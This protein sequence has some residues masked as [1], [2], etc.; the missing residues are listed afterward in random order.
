[1]NTQQHAGR[2]ERFVRR[3]EYDD[4]HVVAVDLPVAGESV[5][6]EA[7]DETAIVVIDLGDEVV[8]TDVELPGAAERVDATNGVVTVEVAK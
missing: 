7:V 5:E 6:V 8:E 1:M 4:R 2:E 3:Y